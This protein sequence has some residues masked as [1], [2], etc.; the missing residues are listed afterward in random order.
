MSYY[1]NGTGH[2]VS[3]SHL[4]NLDGA[5]QVTVSW[6]QKNAA[7]TGSIVD[8]VSGNYGFLCVPNTGDVPPKGLLT[9]FRNNTT[10]YLNFDFT[11]GGYTFGWTHFLV[12]YDG[13]LGSTARV[14]VW[15]GGTERSRTSGSSDASVGSTGTA[16]LNIGEN[17]Q[18]TYLGEVAIWVGS[19]ITDSTK[20]SDLVAGR[21]PLA[22]QSSNLVFYAR[23]KD[24]PDDSVGSKTGTVTSATLYASENPTVDD[25]PAGSADLQ[26]II[27]EYEGN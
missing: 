22:V 15:S 5:T 3:F 4:A 20:I 21:S 17:S 10:N 18:A 19:A 25:P 23:L 1:F 27:A 7:S 14:R 16:A 13:S 24:G 8:Q 9:A 12:V 11:Y 2:K 6:W 26:A